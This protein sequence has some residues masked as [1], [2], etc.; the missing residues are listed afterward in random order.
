MA[1]KKKQITAQET[2]GALFPLSLQLQHLLE[3]NEDTL[4]HEY[5][6]TYLDW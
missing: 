5:K 2:G 3:E 6:I 1:G 4:K